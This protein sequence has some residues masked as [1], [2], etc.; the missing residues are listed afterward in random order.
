M[1][2]LNIN[3]AEKLCTL[4]GNATWPN[5]GLDESK[6]DPIDTV[7]CYLYQQRAQPPE[8]SSDLVARKEED[9]YLHH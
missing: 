8:T 3:S 1:S 7:I 5:Y 9:H 6:C 2:D 4:Q